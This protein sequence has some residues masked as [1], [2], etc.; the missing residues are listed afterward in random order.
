MYS[1]TIH[2]V[3]IISIS[4]LLLSCGL[5]GNK[6]KIKIKDDKITI[7]DL[8]NAGEQIQENMDEAAKKKEE[9]RKRGDTLALNYKELQQYL[10]SPA[11]YEKAGEPDGESV[12]MPA[13]GSFSKAEQR[14]KSGDKRLQV[15]LIDYNQSDFGYTTATAMFAMSMQIENDREKSGTFETGMKDVKGYEQVYKKDQ[16]AA[17]TYAIANRF[18]LRLALNGSNDVEELKTIAKGMNLSELAS[19]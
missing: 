14:Y 10:P 18:L 7:S 3:S 12:N 19:K 1:K 5:G 4:L 17:V 16:Q 9:R 13:L 6:Q 11:G 2:H 15:E 8:K